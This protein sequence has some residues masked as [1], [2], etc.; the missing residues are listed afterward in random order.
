LNPFT[1]YSSAE[2]VRTCRFE[3]VPQHVALA[4]HEHPINSL[5]ASVRLVPDIENSHFDSTDNW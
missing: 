4:A 1:E 5:D 3:Q 2:G